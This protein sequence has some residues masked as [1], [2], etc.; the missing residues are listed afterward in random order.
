MRT[1][2]AV[3]RRRY[4]E[5]GAAA[6]DVDDLGGGV[7]ERG[8]RAGSRWLKTRA[9]MTFRPSGRL[10][11]VI[12]TSMNQFVAA[13]WLHFSKKP[14]DDA[15]VGGVPVVGGGQLRAAIAPLEHDGVH[16]CRRSGGGS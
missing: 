3:G 4:R 16:R 5:L 14:P 13:A 8:H 15:S 12:W 7:E 9:L 6:V 2:G 1:S 11:P 10:V